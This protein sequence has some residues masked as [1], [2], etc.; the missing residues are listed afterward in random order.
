LSERYWT[1]VVDVSRTM[2]TDCVSLDDHSAVALAFSRATMLS[3]RIES[4]SAYIREQVQV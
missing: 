2:T 1:E 4:G 3:V